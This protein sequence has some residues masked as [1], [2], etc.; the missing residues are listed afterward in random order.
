MWDK[1]PTE[2]DAPMGSSLRQSSR[3]VS[4]EA[5]NS[6]RLQVDEGGR[7]KSSRQHGAHKV[8]AV[9]SPQLLEPSTSDPPYVLVLEPKSS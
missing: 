3:K 1:P 4:H 5:T 2:E 6:I 8:P 7:N 9:N